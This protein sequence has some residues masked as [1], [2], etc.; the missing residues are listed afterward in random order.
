M[1]RT[2]RSARFSRAVP[3]KRAFCA[4]A[5]GYKGPFWW[6]EAWPV[7]R[8]GGPAVTYARPSPELSE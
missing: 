7:V 8:L 5:R 1:G 3:I 2:R 6:A 4:H